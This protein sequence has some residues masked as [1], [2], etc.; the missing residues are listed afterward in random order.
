MRDSF[1]SEEPGAHIDSVKN[2]IMLDNQYYGIGAV[3][4]FNEV[5]VDDGARQGNS[6]HAWEMV[7]VNSGS[8]V[9][10]SIYSDEDI[11]IRSGKGKESNS[12]VVLIGDVLAKEKLEIEPPNEQGESGAV[13]VLGNIYAK[14]INVRG[15]LFVQGNV[16]AT[17]SLMVK[18]PMFVAGR[19]K[20]GRNPFEDSHGKVISI[21]GKAELS[22]T[23]AFGITCHGDLKFHQK[24]SV[25]EPIVIARNGDIYMK[26]REQL[27]VISDVCLNCI[28]CEA[29]PFMCQEYL[30]GRCSE[31]EYLMAED[32][33]KYRNTTTLS[34]YWRAGLGM[35]SHHYTIHKLYEKA[36]KRFDSS[37]FRQDGINSISFE[38]AYQDCI[39]ALVEID[40][41]RNS[42]AKW[43]ASKLMD[44]GNLSGEKYYKILQK[45]L[46]GPPTDEEIQLKRLQPQE[47]E[48]TNVIE[49]YLKKPNDREMLTESGEEM[50]IQQES[51]E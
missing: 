38:N 1:V 17:R 16:Y 51:D 12:S 41:S 8:A 11:I 29:D 18:S 10:G 46:P 23:A 22:Y 5:L 34:W 32:A 44:A 9:H 2:K 28:D 36:L 47:I 35:L 30:G 50:D 6:I 21:K 42:H 3:C 4:N 39:A 15:E 49:S 40:S 45:M 25:V 31:F 20:I 43:F 19:I 33:S 48:E 27:R 13:V 37:A 7:V 26:E 14:E 24:N